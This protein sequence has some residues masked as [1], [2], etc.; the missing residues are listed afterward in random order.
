MRIMAGKWNKS[1]TDFHCVMPNAD[2]YVMIDG[3]DTYLA[4]TEPVMVAKM[5]EGHASSAVLPIE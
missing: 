4:G 2:A 1:G 3:D 5:L